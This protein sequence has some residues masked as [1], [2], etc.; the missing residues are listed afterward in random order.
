MGDLQGRTREE[1]VPVLETTTMDRENPAPDADNIL[2]HGGEP[3]QLLCEAWQSLFQR[4]SRRGGRD[5]VL[6]ATWIHRN[7]CFQFR[8]H[9]SGREGIPSVGGVSA[10]AVE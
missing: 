4:A 7:R 10:R 1:F 8:Q 9:E 2:R 3:K 6:H 5:Q